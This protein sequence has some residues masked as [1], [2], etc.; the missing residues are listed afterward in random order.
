MVLLAISAEATHFHAESLQK[1]PHSKKAE[2]GCI[3][4]HGLHSPVIA[5]PSTFS[6]TDIS[7]DVI[8]SALSVDRPSQ[9]QAFALFVRPP[10]S[11]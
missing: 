2:G 9:L 6:G 5:T 1:T 10:P 11:C 3:I 8:T 7:T 4:C